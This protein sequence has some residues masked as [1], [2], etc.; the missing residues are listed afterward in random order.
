MNEIIDEM[1]VEE[2]ESVFSEELNNKMHKMIEEE[3]LPMENA[4]LLL[5]RIGY[6]KLLRNFWMVNFDNS[7]LCKRLK[8]M[9]CEEEEEEEE[10]KRRRKNPKLLIDLCECCAMLRFYYNSKEELP[11]IAVPC[12]LKVGLNKKGSREAQKEVEMAVL[13]LSNIGSV[14]PGNEDLYFNEMREIIQ[15][16]QEHRNLTRL[17]YQSAWKFLINRLRYDKSFEENFVNE[18]KFIREASRELEELTKSVDWKRK[19]GEE[20]GTESQEELVLMRWLYALRCFILGCKLWREEYVGIISSIAQLLREAKDNHI[21][22]RNSCIRIFYET[23]TGNKSA[24]VD[25][26]LKGGAV[27]AVWGELHKSAMDNEIA[28]KILKFFMNVSK[29]LKE[30]DKEEKEKAKRKETKMELF[31]KMEEEGYEDIITSF[32]KIYVYLNR[33]YNHELSLNISDYLMNV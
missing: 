33:K 19:D 29:K 3:K 16:H 23:A 21:K 15:H 7:R 4:I 22:I 17:A 25:F 24:K 20:R 26:L 30:E 32:Y 5:E 28:A 2:F 6:C 12:L 8:E 14:A 1:N 13:A 9:I 31:E 10:R 27:D 18:L 11:A